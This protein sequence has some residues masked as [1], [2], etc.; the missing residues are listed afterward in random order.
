MSGIHVTAKAIFERLVLVPRPRC[1]VQ[2]VIMPLAPNPPPLNLQLFL[3]SLEF[4]GI[5][6]FF[7]KAREVLSCKIVELRNLPPSHNLDISFGIDIPPSPRAV[8]AACRLAV[9]R[10][11][12]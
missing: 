6:W 3:D 1:F 8:R 5:P 12:G 7:W 10:I 9:A 11:W 2:F 4:F